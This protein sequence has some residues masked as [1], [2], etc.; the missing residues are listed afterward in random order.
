[1]LPHGILKPV[2][3][4]A[5]TGH[6]IRIAIEYFY[7]KVVAADV[8]SHFNPI[9]SKPIAQ[10]HDSGVVSRCDVRIVPRTKSE[11]GSKGHGRDG[12]ILLLSITS[13]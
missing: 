10:M 7:S 2:N 9:C 13:C 3:V 5:R 12:K 1:M 11:R 8:L 6:D 4:D